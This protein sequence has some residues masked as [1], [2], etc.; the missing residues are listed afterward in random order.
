MARD[1]MNEYKAELD[2]TIIDFKVTK[3]QIT[4]DAH[5]KR[6]TALFAKYFAARDEKRAMF[7]LKLWPNESE[8]STN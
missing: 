8:Y 4:C 3:E 5:E 1:C 2:K 7:R 6:A